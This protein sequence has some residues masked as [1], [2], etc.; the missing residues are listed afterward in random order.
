VKPL[1]RVYLAAALAA[2]GLGAVA[3]GRQIVAPVPQAKS[4]CLETQF[5]S[6]VA[7]QRPPRARI[8]L[9]ACPHFDETTLDLWIDAPF[10]SADL[11][12]LIF[13]GSGPRDPHRWPQYLRVRWL[14]EDSLLVEHT[15]DIHFLDRRDSAGAIRILYHEF[16][17]ES[18]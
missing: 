10:D 14:N 16:V 2:L 6:A 12:G 1:P 9:F 3:V 15:T 7:G 4:G 18:P 5:D 11:G 17:G 13:R 8:Q